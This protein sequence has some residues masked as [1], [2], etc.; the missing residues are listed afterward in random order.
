[1]YDHIE[2]KFQKGFTLLTLGWSDGYNF[3]PVGFNMLSSV[4]KS[5]RYQEIITDI[6]CRCN[7]YKARKESLM[8]KT[9]AAI[10][11]IERALNVGIRA[12]YVLTD[13]WFTTE[14]MIKS[15]L[16]KGLDEIG[17]V[18]QLNQR[19]NYKGKIYTLP[20]L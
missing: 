18:K 8:A 6:D 9:D 5:N 14:S 19:Y 4:I 12:N 1:M 3:V 2:H 17:M 16:S 13:T 7:G 15:I 20:E 11:M 10:L